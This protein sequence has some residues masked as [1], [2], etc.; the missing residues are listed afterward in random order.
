MKK[1]RILGVCSCCD[2]GNLDFGGVEKF[3]CVVSYREALSVFVV[4]LAAVMNALLLIRE[5]LA[6][7]LRR[8]ICPCDLLNKGGG[9][10]VGGCPFEEMKSLRHIG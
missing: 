10:S 5:G 3:E 6:Y 8:G 2:G 1:V 9:C 7:F 4:S